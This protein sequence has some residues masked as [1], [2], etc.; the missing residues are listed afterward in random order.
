MDDGCGCRDAVPTPRIIM[1][2]PIGSVTMSMLL[3]LPWES[4]L[5]EGRWYR[6][7]IR[8]LGFRA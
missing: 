6:R 3:R 4:H 5:L 7:S 8:M 2:P 1:M